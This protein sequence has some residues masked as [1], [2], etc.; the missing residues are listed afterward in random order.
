MTGELSRALQ[1]RFVLAEVIGD[2]CPDP[3]PD[4]VRAQ[5]PGNR[6]LVEAAAVIGAFP[7]GSY[8]SGDIRVSLLTL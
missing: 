8:L 4:L 7:D 3:H 6:E 2:D 5:R 1:G